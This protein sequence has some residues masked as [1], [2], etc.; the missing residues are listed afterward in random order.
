MA[1]M[2]YE[3]AAVHHHENSGFPSFLGGLLVNHIFL[4]PDRG[5]F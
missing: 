2:F 1:A 5:D 4:H 3:D